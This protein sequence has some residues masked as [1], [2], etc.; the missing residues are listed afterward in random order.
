MLN[1]HVHDV[2]GVVWW[3]EKKS[4]EKVMERKSHKKTTIGKKSQK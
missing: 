3:T 1:L 4:Q 2:S